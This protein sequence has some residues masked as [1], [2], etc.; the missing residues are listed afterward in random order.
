MEMDTGNK[1]KRNAENKLPD[2]SAT[3]FFF[4]CHLFSFFNG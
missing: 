3:G 4:N 2:L 1:E